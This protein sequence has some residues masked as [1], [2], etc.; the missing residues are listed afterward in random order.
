MAKKTAHASQQVPKKRGPIDT[1][2]ILPGGLVKKTCQPNITPYAKTTHFMNFMNQKKPLK[3]CFQHRIT[4]AQIRLRSSSLTV[5]NK[6][7]FGPSTMNNDT[8]GR[9]R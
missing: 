8:T 2:P 9:C 1:D 4:K 6:K 3:A 7:Q 5:F